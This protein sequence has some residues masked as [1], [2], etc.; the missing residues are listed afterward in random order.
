MLDFLILSVLVVAI[1]TVSRLKS[2]NGNWGIWACLAIFLLMS[3][4][5]AETIGNDTQEYMRIFNM[6]ERGE[7]DYDTSRYEKGYLAV[8]YLVTFIS[9]NSK[10]L[11]FVCSGFIYYSIGNFIIK[12]SKMP[13]LSLLLFL[14]YGFFT[15]SM[16]AIRQS[17]AIAVLL[18]SFPYIVYKKPI[19]FFILVAIASLFH[20]TAVLFGFA[21]FAR[22][23][24][25][26]PKTIL[27]IL[28]CSLVGYFIF[29]ALLGE[30]LSVFTMYD[31]Y[32][33]GKYFGETRLASIFYVIIS[34]L[35]VALSY[36]IFTTHKNVLR[37]LAKTRQSTLSCEFILV[38][39][40][41]ALYILS[42]KLNILDRI[43]IYYNIFAIV[44]LPNAIRLLKP[45]ERSLMSSI[46][47]ISFFAYSSVL[48]LL[49][50]DW[51]SV[52]PYHFVN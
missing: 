13:A 27:I 51:N 41:V 15:F 10:W 37:K 49:R 3:T 18:F 4:F 1:L 21:Y 28:G 46:V 47:F 2:G 23:L 43:A 12:Y 31:H 33:G 26:N 8:N 11:F 45:R 16:T 48:L 39:F 14:T 22:R 30:L 44:L 50:P 32:S 40:A 25:P 29:N 35:I 24:K 17:M 5:R 20:V 34:S 7:Y 38:L 6:I 42:L 52:F 36:Y 19:K 9:K